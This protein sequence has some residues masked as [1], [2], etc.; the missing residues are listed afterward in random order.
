VTDT[1]TFDSAGQPS[2]L[3]AAATAHTSHAHPNSTTVTTKQDVSALK[4]SLMVAT[5]RYYGLGH[6]IPLFKYQMAIESASDVV[7]H[8]RK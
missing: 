1:W 4:D 6:P 7:A 3:A 5:I 8:K 2:D